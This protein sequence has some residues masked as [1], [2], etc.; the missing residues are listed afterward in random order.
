[1]QPFSIDFAITNR[2]SA[3]SQINKPNYK[4]FYEGTEKI[5]TE[6]ED[7]IKLSFNYDK[8]FWPYFGSMRTQLE[9][10]DT[11]YCRKMEA[12]RVEIVIRF[13]VKSLE[14]FGSI[15]EQGDGS[16]LTQFK[17]LVDFIPT[18]DRSKRILFD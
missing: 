18:P 1:M 14:D 16:I 11:E 4:L 7:C 15:E 5:F 9:A 17:I 6:L 2:N 8:I 12:S 13:S 10:P 3:H